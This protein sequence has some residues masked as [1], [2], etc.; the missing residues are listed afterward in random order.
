MANIYRTLKFFEKYFGSKEII[1][2]KIDIIEQFYHEN[3]GYIIDRNGKFLAFG[4]NTWGQLGTGDNKPRKN[5]HSVEILSRVNIVG[6]YQGKFCMFALTN[7]GDVFSWGEN[8]W[9]QL[10]VGLISKPN[11]YFKPIQMKF[12]HNDEEKK[13]VDLKCG[14]MHNLA[15]TFDKMVFGWGSNRY[16]QIIKNERRIF[17]FPILISFEIEI[18]NIY[19]HS[20]CSFLITNE[21]K[22]YF[23][24]LDSWGIVDTN[25][26]SN[27]NLILNFNAKII[28]CNDYSMFY[29]NQNKNNKLVFELYE[30]KNFISERKA[31]FI[32]KI[33]TNDYNEIF[34]KLNYVSNSKNF[35]EKI[36]GIDIYL[37]E[38]LIWNKYQ[39]IKSDSI[40]YDKLIKLLIEI[41]ENSA[42]WINNFPD[43]SVISSILTTCKFSVYLSPWKYL[44]IEAYQ[45]IYGENLD[46]KHIVIPIIHNKFLLDTVE[47]ES[48]KEIEK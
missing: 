41:Y 27:G 44:W 13:I 26:D 9:G 3:F 14:S 43:I 25:P 42:S 47:E 22:I 30:Y 31:K 24:G 34:N 46:F 21:D 8:H 32:K 37:A 33:I 35:R 18:Q 11:I 45:L 2:D 17:Y 28:I 38:M 48:E 6:I 16:Q 20:C 15:L 10:G 1:I 19:C 39:R 4:D 12:L 23:N 40:E 7:R 5:F 36:K 29:L